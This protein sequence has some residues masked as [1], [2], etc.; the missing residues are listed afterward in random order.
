MKVDLENISVT[1]FLELCQLDKEAMSRAMR[2]CEPDDYVFDFNQLKLKDLALLK[3]EKTLSV[4]P[5]VLKTHICI[6]VLL[7]IFGNSLTTITQS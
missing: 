3:T 1:Q 2:A 7:K 4:F 5:K 6:Y